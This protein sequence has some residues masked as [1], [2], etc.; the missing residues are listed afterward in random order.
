[1][2]QAYISLQRKLIVALEVYRLRMCLNCLLQK[3]Q[4]WVWFQT[5]EEAF[6]HVKK[7]ITTET[8]DLVW[9]IKLACD[10]YPYGIGALTLHVMP[11]C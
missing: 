10:A 2:N 3:G 11:D 6:M 4:N 7:V 9:P 8:L 1:M 5:C